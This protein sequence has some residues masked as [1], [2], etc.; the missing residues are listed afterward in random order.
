M[1]E[2]R[3]ARRAG[4]VGTVRGLTAVAPS[5]CSV[6]GAVGAGLSGIHDGT[7]VTTAAGIAGCTLAAVLAI[8]FARPA[9]PAA[10]GTGEDG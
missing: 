3:P 7:P 10:D 9:D 6:G 4:T 8:A 1:S 5:P 2:P